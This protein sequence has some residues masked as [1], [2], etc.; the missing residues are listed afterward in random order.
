MTAAL[1]RPLAVATTL[2]I[3]VAA[4]VALPLASQAAPSTPRTPSFAA[5]APQLATGSSGEA[6]K[7]LQKALEVKPVTG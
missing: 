2:L 7:V 3:A 1:R 5:E 6:V 4:L